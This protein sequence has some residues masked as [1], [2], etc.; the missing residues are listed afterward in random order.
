LE[1]NWHLGI[2]DSSLVGSVALLGHQTLIK[3]T[4]QWAVFFE[5]LLIVE[6]VYRRENSLEEAFPFILIDCVL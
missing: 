3:E 6:V 4:I 5:K 1:E 2:H